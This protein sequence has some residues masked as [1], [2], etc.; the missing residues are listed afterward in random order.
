MPPIDTPGVPSVEPLPQNVTKIWLRRALT[1][2]LL[3]LL[4]YFFWPLLG[5]IKA[6]AA[7]FRQAN[8]IW[9]GVA[10]LLQGISYWFL[11]WLNALSL[12]PFSGRIGMGSLAAVLTAMAFISVAVPSAGISGVAMRVRLLGKYGYRAEEALFSMVVETVLELI[13]LV[14]VGILGVAY[15]VESGRLEEGN[16]ISLVAIGVLSIVTMGFGWFLVRDPVK[17][18][19]IAFRLVKL[20]NR[21]GGRFRHLEE[22]YVDE[23]LRFFQNNLSHY[24]NSVLWKL[25]LAAYGKVILDVMSLGACFL[26][27]D[28]TI[29][30]STLFIGY[31]LVL[32][33][34]GL[35]ALPGGL[36]MTD[37]M[38][39]VIFS[40]LRVP[41]S[42]A[43]AAGLTY[44][45]IA[46][47]LVRFSGYVSWL[48]LERRR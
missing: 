11:T 29:T 26:L 18:R 27:F 2:V 12:Q 42:V 19:R 31:G 30:P 46:Y 44:R 38:V 8:W 34:S 7:L 43:I 21:M 47:W 22:D 36:A 40:W 5:E 39:P 9:L 16:I 3:G 23:R 45:L 14:S 15:L 24:D 33:F 32:A 28:Y 1:L 48:V 4:V 20:W 13:A 37:A 25:P 35:G 17:S 6:A 41:G 10:L